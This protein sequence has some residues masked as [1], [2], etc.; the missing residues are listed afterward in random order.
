VLKCKKKNRERVLDAAHPTTHRISCHLE[1]RMRLVAPEE[2]FL[3]PSARSLDLTSMSSM[4]KG[5]VK[6]R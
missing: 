5:V 6:E 4:L 2:N 3:A 1:W